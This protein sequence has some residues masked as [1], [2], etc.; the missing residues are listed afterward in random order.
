M[1]EYHLGLVGLFF[2][3]MYRQCIRADSIT[4]VWLYSI[5]CGS[6]VGDKYTDPVMNTWDTRIIPGSKRPFIEKNYYQLTVDTDPGKIFHYI[7][8]T[9]PGPHGSCSFA[10]KP[11][12]SILS[13]FTTRDFKPY[14]YPMYYT[15]ERASPEEP[16]IQS[17]VNA[18]PDQNPFLTKCTSGNNE[19]CI[20]RIWNK[21]TLRIIFMVFCYHTEVISCAREC[22]NGEVIVKFSMHGMWIK[23][24]TCCVVTGQYAN[25]YASIDTVNPFHS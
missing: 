10:Q 17:L 14:L 25:S 18:Y 8:E 9:H 21:E 11:D 15:F 5:D 1:Q 22:N 3:C 2:S 16:M 20:F 19:K 7:G 6:Y 4:G 23:L 12:P 13:S 24:N